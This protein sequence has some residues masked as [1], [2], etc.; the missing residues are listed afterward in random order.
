MIEF[1]QRPTFRSIA[2]LLLVALPIVFLAWLLKTVMLPIVV[3]SVMYVL[4]DPAVNLLRQR[5]VNKTLA[6]T[7]VLTV[8]IG[9]ARK[10]TRVG[11]VGRPLVQIELE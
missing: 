7:I 8:V 1:I 6:I 2:I 5:G 9:M 3:S 4:L 10:S 11:R